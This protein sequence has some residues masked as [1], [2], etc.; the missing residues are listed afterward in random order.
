[1][2]INTSACIL[3]DDDDDDN[4]AFNGQSESQR[5]TILK[6][7]LWSSVIMSIG[8]R[9]RDISESVTGP[10]E[11]SHSDVGHPSLMGLHNRSPLGEWNESDV[12][13]RTHDW[14]KQVGHERL[15]RY[16]SRQTDKAKED[17]WTEIKR[18]SRRRESNEGSASRNWRQHPKSNP[19]WERAFGAG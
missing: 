17:G 1:M 10:L 13:D 19:G 2:K 5:R 15:K 9:G 7:V 11:S 14:S 6:F 16:G 8:V 3:Y 4:Q 12:N 18:K